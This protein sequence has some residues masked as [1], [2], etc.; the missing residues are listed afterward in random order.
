MHKR[1]RAHVRAA[2]KYMEDDTRKAIAHFGRA[3]HYFGGE[4]AP[5][6][7]DPNETK[8]HYSS[9]RHADTVTGQAKF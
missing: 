1:A 6:S 3:M 4:D 5:V 9:L 8:E 7:A 2:E